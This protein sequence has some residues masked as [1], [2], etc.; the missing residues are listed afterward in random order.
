MEEVN[1]MS[2][3]QQMTAEEE[4]HG[5]FGTAEREIACGWILYRK[6]GILYNGKGS[7]LIGG[8]MQGV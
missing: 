3:K 4:G 2:G 6:Y 1:E 8:S 5:V 7:L